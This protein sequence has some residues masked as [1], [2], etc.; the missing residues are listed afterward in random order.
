MLSFT[1][2][3][4]RISVFS[5]QWLGNTATFSRETFVRVLTTVSY[6]VMACLLLASVREAK[7]AELNTTTFSVIAIEYAPFTSP[8]LPEGGSV[9]QILNGILRSKG[10]FS[11]V[12]RFYPPARA[13]AIISG[14]DWD[15]S[16]YPPQHDLRSRYRNIEL[17]TEPLRISLFRIRQDNEV[18]SWQNLSDLQGRVVFG[19]RLSEGPLRKRLTA[20]GLEV[21]NTDSLEHG[22]RLLRYQRAEYVFAEYSAGL[23]AARKAGLRR[24]QIQF[25]D[26]ILLAV[27]V[28]IW[29]NPETVPGNYLIQLLK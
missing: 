4:K 19:R 10:A 7:A 21:I 15:A 5:S 1:C 8:D 22:F 25:A 6:L 27:P 9:F 2:L 26:N 17:D 16:F 3:N 28:N 18:F 20:A 29:V 11:S 12:A 23:A 13:D 24:D 14:G